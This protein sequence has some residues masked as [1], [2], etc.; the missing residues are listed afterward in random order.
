MV[1]L[2]ILFSKGIKL[3]LFVLLLKYVSLFSKCYRNKQKLR[4]IFFSHATWVT[5][6]G[7]QHG[8]WSHFPPFFLT[9]PLLG[10]PG[11]RPLQQCNQKYSKITKNCPEYI[12]SVVKVSSCS[13]QKTVFAFCQQ[14]EL[15]QFEFFAF[16]HNMIF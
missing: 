1:H 8:K 6:V 10:H 9:L 7:G 15:S 2:K 11:G 12:S 3:F 14:I 13:Y 5:I 4:Q 16:C